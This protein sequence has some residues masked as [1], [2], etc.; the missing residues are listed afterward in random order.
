M[1]FKLIKTDLRKP[2]L[3]FGSITLSLIVICSI[4]L[5]S[6]PLSTKEKIT[7]VCQINL[8]FILI[9]LVC[10]TTN[11]SKTSVSLFYNM[12]VTTNIETEE[13]TLKIIKNRFVYTFIIL[14]TVGAF[15]IEL[16]SG[17]LINKISWAENAKKTWWIFFILFWIN[18]TYL[19]LFFEITKYLISLN[20]D[21]KKAYLD[22]IKNPPKKEVETKS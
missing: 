18:F 2:I 14:F 20:E 13:K 17:S 8:N 7:L 21:F 3:W 16:T 1:D 19:I 15:F 4:I 11:L 6:I 12:E 9:Y 10:L 22:F 5:L